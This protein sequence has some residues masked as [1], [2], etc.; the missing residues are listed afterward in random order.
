MVGAAG[1]LTEA[2]CDGLL[3]AYG[4]AEG[5]VGYVCLVYNHWPTHRD[6]IAE[7]NEERVAQG[8]SPDECR[9]FMLFSLAQEERRLRS[10]RRKVIKRKP[11]ER[12]RQAALRE[13]D[14]ACLVLP[15]E[16]ATNRL[17]RYETAIERQLYRALAE[18]ERLQRG[19][20]AVALSPPGH[21]D[22][23]PN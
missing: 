20:A 13:L 15:P 8:P 7:E 21:P 3:N 22:A 4:K 17:F 14:Q 10:L 1:Q 19:R 2:A 11:L 12:E 6:E 23:S 16:A 9:S 5:S 18:L